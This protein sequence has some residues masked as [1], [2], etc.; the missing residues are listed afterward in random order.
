MATQGVVPQVF[1][2]E[3]ESIFEDPRTALVKSPRL[4][5]AKSSDT[6]RHAQTV[7]A[8][9]HSSHIFLQ[10]L[11]ANDVG[12][13]SIPGKA[14]YSCMLNQQG[15]IIDDLITYYMN[16]NWYRMVV[17]AATREKD[18]KWITEQAKPFN[19]DITERTDLSMIAVQGPNAREKTHKLLGDKISAAHELKPFFAA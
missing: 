18:L 16:D 8:V 9:V 10:F 5:L 14:L 17:N 6:H 4:R 19:I 2:R 13:L 11:L 15:G 12:K 1:R 7:L 3:Q